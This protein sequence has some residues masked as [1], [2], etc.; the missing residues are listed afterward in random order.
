MLKPA[1]ADNGRR[2]L[3]YRLLLKIAAPVF[4]TS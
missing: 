4:A 1:D 2:M 3:P